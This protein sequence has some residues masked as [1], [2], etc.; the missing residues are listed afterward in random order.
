MFRASA[1]F[2]NAEQQ[3]MPQGS[4]S[5]LGI[6][7]PKPYK[8]ISLRISTRQWE[9]GKKILPHLGVTS[10]DTPAGQCQGVTCLAAKTPKPWH[11]H[12][13]PGIGPGPAF[14]ALGTCSHDQN[15]GTHLTQ[16]VCGLLFQSSL[17]LHSFIN[18]LQPFWSKFSVFSFALSSSAPSESRDEELPQ[19][20]SLETSQ[21]FQVTAF[22]IWCFLLP[23]K[24]FSWQSTARQMPCAKI[25]EDSLHLSRFQIC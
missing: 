23:F 2:S 10:C 12:S 11:G 20:A 9:T 21:Y 17:N 7:C 22:A 14:P 4:S 3:M 6:K 8:I 16:G 15:W 25:N 18:S 1:L 13:W 19:P 5:L 24:F